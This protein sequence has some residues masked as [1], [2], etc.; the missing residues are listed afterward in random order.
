MNRAMLVLVSF[1]LS[2]VFAAPGTSAKTA[3]GKFADYKIMV[4]PTEP[5]NPPEIGQWMFQSAVQASQDTFVLG[6]WQFDNGGAPDAQGWTAHD[7][8]EEPTY[9]HVAG[10]P[11]SCDPISPIAGT[12]SMWCGVWP[13]SADPWCGW[14]SLPGYGNSWDQSLEAQGVSTLSYSIEWDTEPYLDFAYLEWWDSANHTWVSDNTVNGDL[15]F[16]TGTGSLSESVTSPYGSTK[17]RIH[18]VSDG[19]WSD[20][21]GLAPTVEG[22]VKIDDLSIDGGPIEDW[23]DEACGALQSSDGTWV[24]AAYPAFG[25]YAHLVHG[26]DVVQED[27]ALTSALFSGRFSMTP[28]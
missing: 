5:S 15:G 28:R 1:V 19:A 22:A 6:S 17:V 13:T 24:A 23:E 18:F 16:Y 12:K 14:V 9:F 2:A 10:S 21:D 8:T 25:L 7:V 11:G 26:S 27:S 3:P 4:M 20:E